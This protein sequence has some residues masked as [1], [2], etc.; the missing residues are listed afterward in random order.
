MSCWLP[1]LRDIQIFLDVI[2]I[3]EPWI[4]REYESRSI[5]FVRQS[6]H[7]RSN[8]EYVVRR[9]F[10]CDLKSLKKLI[11]LKLTISIKKPTSIII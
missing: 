5:Y 2:K 4:F 10:S 11:S 8:P 3:P 9:P 7:F 6:G 1:I